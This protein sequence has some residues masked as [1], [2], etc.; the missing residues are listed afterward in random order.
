MNMPLFDD[1]IQ[2]SN[3]L[4]HVIHAPTVPSQHMPM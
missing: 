4:P 1:F 2:V 3:A